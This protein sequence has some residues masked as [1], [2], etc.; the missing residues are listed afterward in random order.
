MVNLYDVSVPVVIRALEQLAD[1]LK[2]GEKWCEDNKKEKT[3]LTEGKISDMLPLTFQVQSACNSAKGVLFRVG[4]EEN[5][6]VE[7]NEKT[8]EEMI[9]R[10]ESTLALLKA[11]KREKF[12]DEVSFIEIRYRGMG[13]VLIW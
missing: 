8:F 9:A 5:T 6:P 7:D 2:I 12:I 11:A 3:V 10:V 1:N 4:G 13:T